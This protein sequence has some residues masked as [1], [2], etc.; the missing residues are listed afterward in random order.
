MLEYALVG[1]NW[2]VVWGVGDRKE[3]EMGDEEEGGNGETR[4]EEE[5]EEIG[6]FDGGEEEGFPWLLEKVSNRFCGGR[7]HLKSDGKLRYGIK[8]PR[9]FI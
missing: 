4:F 9:V 6:G 5:R 7:R 2:V 8:I 3:E 1:F